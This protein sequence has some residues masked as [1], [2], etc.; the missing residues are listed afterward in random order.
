MET[1]GSGGQTLPG[2]LTLDHRLS[3]VGPQDGRGA[4]DLWFVPQ[5]EGVDEG[6]LSHLKGQSPTHCHIPK[7]AKYIPHI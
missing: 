4:D 5:S 2:I 6:L 3:G 1:L 7:D